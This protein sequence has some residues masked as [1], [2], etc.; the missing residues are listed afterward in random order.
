M[1]KI[2][3]AFLISFSANSFSQTLEWAKM[4][5]SSDTESAYEVIEDDNGDVYTIG[6]FEGLVDFDP[7]AGVANLLS[8]GSPDFFIQKLNSDGNFVWIK[9]L[10]GDNNIFSK[11]IVIDTTGNL[12]I[13]GYFEGTVDF[14]PGAAVFNK[15]SNGGNDIFILKLDS[16]G[17]FI[18]AKTIGGSQHDISASVICDDFGFLFITGSFHATV[19]FDPNAGV[20]N[21]TTSGGEEIFVL[22]LNLAGDFIWAKQL[23]GSTFSNGVALKPDNIGGVYLT[24]EFYGGPV[25]FDPSAGSQLITSLGN[26]D[27]F[28][29][30]F[31]SAGEIIWVKQIGGTGNDKPSQIEIDENGDLYILGTFTG[32]SDFDPGVS[33]YNLSSIGNQDVFICKLNSVG[34]FIWAQSFGSATID[35]GSGL[36]VK[37][38]SLFITG[39]FSTTVDFDP[40]VAVES[41]SSAGG[42]DA[43]ILELTTAGNYSDVWTFGSIEDEYGLGLSNSTGSKIIACGSF[44]ET[45][46]FDPF[47][48]VYNL[49]SNGERD[50][51]TLKIDFCAS[52][53]GT[54]TQASCGPYLWID[55]NTYTSDEFSATHTLTNVAGCDSVVTL[56]LT[57]ASPNTGTDVQNECGPYMWIDG[58]TYTSDEFSATYTLTNVAGCDSVVT[59]NLTI[60]SPNTGTDV[61][62]QC[63]PF[64]WIDGN[65]YTS[66]EF[67]AS[68]TLTNVAGCDSVVTLNL[69]V[70]SP[71][72]GTDVQN[73]CG[74]YMWIDG[75]TYTSDEFSATHTLTNMNG[76]DSVVTLNLSISNPTSSTD[77]QASCGPYLWMD[78]NTYTSNEN[79][80]THTLTNIA[81]CDSVITLNLTI[82]TIDISVI[83]DADSIFANHVGA[84]YQWLDCDDNFTQ[85]SGAT[86]QTFV[87]A[88][89][90]NYAV[91]IAQNGCIDTS[92]C[93]QIDG[94]GIESFESM[95]VQVF[96]NP[97]N[98]TFN[99]ILSNIDSP[100]Q[101]IV[102]DLSGRTIIKQEMTDNQFQI[103]LNAFEDG[104]YLLNVKSESDKAKIRLV[105]N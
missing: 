90:G 44:Q 100:V 43:Y 22:K 88:N 56:N 89:N 39:T 12:L 8:T 13:T 16:N 97:S 94:V 4:A 31:N 50:A 64:L 21:L 1:S 33:T 69:T 59:L 105:K 58:N 99:I 92:D 75:N 81:G 57:I 3:L 82:T 23:S 36:V 53:S 67:S 20:S 68:H 17:D 102:S 84:N 7:G 37:S 38:E 6:L 74:S 87:T 45:I 2:A 54:D 32:T 98:G 86:N 24:G 72:T 60:A 55:G 71:N 27:T 49:T 19:D 52:T 35:Y 96:P 42:R 48:P 15:T 83:L 85:I 62:N 91:E 101:L 34:I 18:W 80:A 79:S 25:D 11:S 77:I 103:D 14:N 30:H 29:E 40:G 26:F 10:K 104:L 28:V 41:I 9:Q 65:T 5:G 78:G 51:F 63:G 93:V 95:T 47:A 46:D 73:Q 61:Q 76:C 70:S 66:N